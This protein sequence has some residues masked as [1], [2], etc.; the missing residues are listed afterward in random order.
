MTKWRLI[1][2]M[3]S[4]QF[5][6]LANQ[7]DKHLNIS[8]DAGKGFDKIKQPSLIKTLSKLK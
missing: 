6:I 7:K 2:K 8:T 3:Q 1:F 5:S 4:V